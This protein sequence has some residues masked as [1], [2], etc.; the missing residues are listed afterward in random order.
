VKPSQIHHVAINVSDVPK[1]LDFYVGALGLTERSDRPDFG[2]GGAWLDVGPGQVHLV[3]L[4]VPH[5]IGQH[6]AIEY[7][8]LDGVVAELRDKGLEVGDPSAIVGRR[9]A[10]VNDPDGNVIELQGI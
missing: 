9:Q 5:P 8:D 7:D 1:A 2:I 4:P 6:F 3:E 10:F